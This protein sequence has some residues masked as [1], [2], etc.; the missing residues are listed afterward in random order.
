VMAVCEIVAI[1]CSY[2]TDL[3]ALRL[4]LLLDL[5]KQEN[6]GDDEPESRALV[7]WQTTSLSTNLHPTE[8]LR[9]GSED[10]LLHQA[11]LLHQLFESTLALDLTKI[12]HVVVLFEPGLDTIIPV[13]HR[14]D[15]QVFVPG[16][17]RVP[18]TVV[19]FQTPSWFVHLAIRLPERV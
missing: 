4:I 6:Q 10:Q 15:G 2:L 18:H 1:F 14:T 5:A 3:D 19:D 12:A 9:L 17:Q 11:Q 13:H 8:H 16:E 7:Y